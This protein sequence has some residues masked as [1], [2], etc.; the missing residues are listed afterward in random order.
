MDNGMSRWRQISDTLTAEIESGVFEEDRR[1]PNS[2]DLAA[3]FGVNR[4]TVLR[5]LSRLQSEGIV[6][7]ERGRGTYAV[8]NPLQ[9]RLGPKR[10]FEQNLIN[11]NRIPTRKILSVTRLPLPETAAQAL[12]TAPGSEAVFVVIRGEAD[13]VPINIVS[14]YFLLE[15]FP[16]IDEVFRSFG[17]EPTD[18]LS[19]SKIFKEYGVADFRR[20]A[21]RIRSRPPRPEEAR[22]LEIAPVDHVLETDVTLVDS[23]DRPLSYANTSYASSRIELVVDL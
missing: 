1:L 7:M 16:N 5:A 21:V 17:F 3:R 8:V 22:H 2:S 6:R 18:Q 12:R 11:S 13:G 9:L 15:H 19:F 23:S 4:H 20:K 14:N 10:W